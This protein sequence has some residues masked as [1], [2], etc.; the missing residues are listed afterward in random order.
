M[1][2]SDVSSEYV[3]D[4]ALA[5]NPLGPLAVSAARNGGL[6]R[7][8]WQHAAPYTGY[9]VWRSESPYFLPGEAK[10]EKRAD[11]PPPATGTPTSYD[12][13]GATGNA[14]QNF[15][16]LVRGSGAGS[17][18]ISNRTGEFDFPLTR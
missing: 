16:Y 7:L 14:A 8:A 18:R 17:T 4:V 13:A 11:V 10:S 2:R 9:A 15:F 12:D 6:V 3:D 1:M 5:A